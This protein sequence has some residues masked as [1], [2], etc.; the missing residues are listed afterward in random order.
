M[1]G[2]SKVCRCAGKCRTPR[3]T[4]GI[5]VTLFHAL[6]ELCDRELED[7]PPPR[8]QPYRA[9]APGTE[10]CATRPQVPPGGASSD[11]NV[12]PTTRWRPSGRHSTRFTGSFLITSSGISYS[13]PST[14]LS[15]GSAPCQHGASSNA[16][17]WR[18]P[19][20]PDPRH[21]CKRRGHAGPAAPAPAARGRPKAGAGQAG[22]GPAARA[23]GSRS[24]ATAD[25]QSAC[26]RGRA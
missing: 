8:S 7:S 23:F 15:A 1:G 12:R 24:T 13:D 6:L 9:D 11:G 16:Q 14:P 2:W 22:S 18:V 10:L 20:L 26:A 5:D 17:Q 3:C 21:A 19:R 4:R 25:V